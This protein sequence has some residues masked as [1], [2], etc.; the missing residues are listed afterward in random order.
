MDFSK[1]GRSVGNFFNGV[2]G[3]ESE[4]EKRKKRQ[5][6]AAK[7]KQPAPKPKVTQPGQLFGQKKPVDVANPDILKVKPLNQTQPKPPVVA[8]PKTNFKPY[9]PL[10]FFGDTVAKPVYN[11]VV[12][13]P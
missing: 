1:I 2:F 8:K 12:E 6:Q 7:Q 10:D 4:E 5:Q 9:T 11:F 3:G 13:E